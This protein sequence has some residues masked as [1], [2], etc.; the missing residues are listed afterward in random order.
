MEIFLRILSDD[1]AVERRFQLTVFNISRAS[2]KIVVRR[3]YATRMARELE[4]KRASSLVAAEVHPDP[5]ALLVNG[6][7]GRDGG[8]SGS[9]RR[10]CRGGRGPQ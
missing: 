1:C 5:H 3:S 2:I 7:Y 10:G 6:G 4:K 9:A 8:G